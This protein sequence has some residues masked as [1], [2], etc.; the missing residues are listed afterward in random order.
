MLAYSCYVL[1]SLKHS[2]RMPPIFPETKLR[3]GTYFQKAELILRHHGASRILL[4]DL[5]R[6]L[7]DYQAHV[8]A[9]ENKTGNTHLTFMQ[10][11]TSPHPFP[12]PLLQIPTSTFRSA[13]KIPDEFV[14]PAR[15][16]Y[17]KPHSW[18]PPLPTYR[19]H[20]G[21][22]TFF[23]ETVKYE[24]AQQLKRERG[25]RRE[26]RRRKH[27]KHQ[28]QRAPTTSLI[29]APTA[30]P[31][32]RPELRAIDRATIDPQCPATISSIQP[33]T[34][35]PHLPPS[36]Q[37]RT[38]RAGTS[39]RS[40]CPPARSSRPSQ[41]TRFTRLAGQVALPATISGLLVQLFFFVVV[42]AVVHRDR[43]PL[44]RQ[45]RERDRCKRCCDADN[46]AVP[47]PTPSIA[48]RATF[49]SARQQQRAAAPAS[50]PTAARVR[51]SM[52]RAV[53]LPVS[54]YLGAGLRHGC[55]AVPPASFAR[56]GDR[57]GLGLLG[58]WSWS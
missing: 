50:S 47:V 32:P 35:R 58:G 56:R 3:L 49:P 1:K 54:T 33:S 8:Q 21:L 38:W 53:P 18:T 19:F 26:Q 45:H 9:R 7:A 23:E 46:P 17:R 16:R 22:A 41:T 51:G 15:H 4:K 31:R 11:Q 52:H 13:S 34:S 48:A 24:V 29:P 39:A 42:V 30:T 20:K 36:R 57:V 37:R 12:S 44:Q 25:E 40:R 28:S 5:N 10:T 14:T 43:S 27:R 55:G 2:S 6:E